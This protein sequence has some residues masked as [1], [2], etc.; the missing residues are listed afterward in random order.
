MKQSA[1]AVFALSLLVSIGIV[2]C[3]QAHV[4]GPGSRELSM[5]FPAYVTIQRGSD[6]MVDVTITRV[7]TREPVTI[8]I[9]QLPSGVTAKQSS[10]TVETDEVTFILQADRDAALVSNQQVALTIQGERNSQSAT[11]HFH[12]AVTE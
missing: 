12:L 1:I 5:T 11:D 8:S 6:R 3:Q 7:A 10:Q 2:G 9:S 4:S